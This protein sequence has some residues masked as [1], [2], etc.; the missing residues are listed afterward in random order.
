MDLRVLSLNNDLKLAGGDYEIIK[1]SL[2]AIKNRN[3]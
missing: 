2:C 3:H 1:K